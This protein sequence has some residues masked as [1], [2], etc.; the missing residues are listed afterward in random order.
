MSVWVA[1]VLL[2]IVTGLAAEAWRRTRGV[3]PVPAAPASVPQPAPRPA[4][5][6]PPPPAESLA[7]RL[8][9]LATSLEAFAENS[10]NPQQLADQPEFRELAEAFTDANMSAE[11]LAQYAIGAN[12]ILSCGA[13]V[14]LSAHPARDRVSGQILRQFANYS[15]W[16][17]HFALFYLTSLERRPPA[18][19]PFVFAQIWWENSPLGA[20]TFRTYLARRSSLGD[21]ATFGDSLDSPFRQPPER[22]DAVLRKV[23]HPYA[24][25]LRD[26]LRRWLDRRL[27]E[28]FLRGLGRFWT[29]DLRLIEPGPW[30]E[31]LTRAEEAV[32]HQPPRSVM[33]SGEPRSGKTSFLKLLA[34]RLKQAGW[35][36]LEASAAELMAGQIYIGQLEG[37]IRQVVA[38]LDAK[39]R[40][41][42]YVMDLL[43]LA[44]SGTHRGQAA[45]ILDQILPA[46][47]SG[48]LVILAESNPAG[49]AR[50]LQ[51]RPALRSA[52]EICRLEPMDQTAALA[53]AKHLAQEIERESRLHV[54]DD[55]ITAAFQ[56]SQQ[57]L[58]GHQLPGNALDLLT[59]SAARAEAA[60][61]TALTTDAVLATLSQLTGLP[62]SI[63]DDK[64][65]VDLQAVRAFFASRVIG[66]PEAVNAVIDRIAMLKAGLTDP[67]RPIGV[68]LFAGPT[69]TGKTELAKTLAEYL[70]GAPERMTRLD[71]SEFQTADSLNKILGERGYISSDSLAERIRKEP[72]SVILLDEFEKAHPNIW[73]L[74]LQIFDDGRLTDANGRIADFR[75]AFIILTSNLGAISHRVSGLGFLPGT[76]AFADDQV[77]QAIARAFRPEFVN[78]LDRVIV[79]KP[80]SRELMREILQKELKGVLERRGLRRRDWAVEWES[81]AIEFLL[82]KGFSAEM[83]ARPLKRAID[84]YLLAPLAATLVEHRFPEGDQFLFVRSNGKAIEVEFVNPD[85]EEPAGVPEPAAD[86]VSLASMIL[87]PSGSAAEKGAL[88]QN[89]S[90]IKTRLSSPEWSGLKERLAGEMS[91]PDI[92]SRA[93][94]HALFA[95]LA[96][97]DRVETAA[98]SAEHLHKRF[99]YS[100]GTRKHISRD[101]VARLALQLYLAEQ[102]IA[103]VIEAAPVDA[104]LVVEPVLDGGGGDG[105]ALKQWCAKLAAMYRSW[106]ASR[107]MQLDE[108]AQAGRPILEIGGF[109]AYRTL[110]S[111]AGLHVLEEENGR[112]SVARVKVAQGPQ[113]QPRAQ[114]APRVFAKLLSETQ[115]SSEVVR[116]YREKPA[117]LVRDGKGRWR[118]GKIDAVFK[119]DFDLIGALQQ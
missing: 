19:A 49:L 113:E 90:A 99:E 110:Q 101:M 17:M 64:E 9:R 43:Q 11:A 45:S 58:G 23:D 102:G 67:G 73:D 1:L 7:D 24:G 94:R 26:E 33:V 8:N 75:H 31:L 87:Q 95:R 78:R 97:I 30:K 34:E 106:A 74:F 40:V 88:A 96:L 38:E 44:D 48:R 18:G 66:Q 39:K 60:G 108:S 89:L 71:M 25:Q 117:P 107:R 109:G 16:P 104:L 103:D 10:S 37:R 29:A 36:V 115:E 55:A 65:R 47:T 35:K 91:A 81:S 119:G 116:R 105:E 6:P 112:R 53:V 20:D 27:D 42:W 22:I 54:D 118:S 28:E 41:A 13:L 4:P 76:A 50:L 12:W 14:V 2:L 114:E 32:L 15:V 62:R 51:F 79:F 98:E 85:A 5:P 77:N 70:F 86:S 61:E 93:D 59:R 3:K 63:L 21:A 80:L 84:E 83:G 68:F 111:E 72:F 57:Y 56:L 52:L 82:D 46:L 100:A 92:W 69:G